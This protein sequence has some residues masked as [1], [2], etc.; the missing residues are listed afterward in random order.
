MLNMVQQEVVIMNKEYL[1]KINNMY[2]Y[3]ITVS[4]EDVNNQFVRSIDFTTNI[5]R[6]MTIDETE[7]VLNFRQLLFELLL[8]P[9]DEINIIV[10]DDSNE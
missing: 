7:K 10:K 9:L 1:I 6:A 8:I 3:D 5:N 4:E 2:L